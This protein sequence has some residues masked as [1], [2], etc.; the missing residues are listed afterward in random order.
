MHCTFIGRFLLFAV[1]VFTAMAFPQEPDEHAEEDF[2]TG[3]GLKIR[4]GLEGGYGCR[5]ARV[6]DNDPLADYLEELKTGLNY[7]VSLAYIFGLEYGICLRFSQFIT[8]SAMDND[9]LIST[10]DS[11]IIL[12]GSIENHVTISYVGAGLGQRKIL[13]GGRV[14]FFN[15]VTI[16]ALFY[17]DA[18]K[19]VNL[20]FDRIGS[21]FG[22]GGAL[23]FDFMITDNVALGFN[24][25]YVLG[26]LSSLKINGETVNLDTNEGLTRFDFNLGLRFYR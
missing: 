4:I 5:L 19:S 16:G 12:P 26:S 20:S 25:A 23:G 24:V 3:K 10:I 7:G 15:E 17:T 18:F 2:D 6:A 14:L 13:G 11:A 1:M 22:L 9:T 8:S 21:T